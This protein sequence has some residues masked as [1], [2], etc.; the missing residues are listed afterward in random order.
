[1]RAHRQRLDTPQVN[2]VFLQLGIESWKPVLSA[3]LLP[4]VP[5]LVLALLGA[6]FILWRR[7]LGWLL[8]LLS[9][10]GLWL[11]AC[12]AVGDWLQAHLLSPP[13]ALTADA[14]ADLKRAAVRP[15]VAIVVLGGGREARAPEYGVASLS[16]LS[17]ERL[18]YGIWLGRE[19]GAPV[20]F[21]GGLGH[22]A[23]PGATEAEI[24]AEIAAREF[25]R[26]LRW[27]E[28]KARDTRE[29]AVF[30]T[31]LLREQGIRQLVIVTHGWH[32]PRAL[33]AFKQVADHDKL[34]WE[35]VPAPMGLGQR[36]ERPALRW[37]PSS[38]GFMS[39]RA[40]LR[41]RFGLWFGA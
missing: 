40:V 16:P 36:V 30:T 17:L 14:L 26:P 37:M 27:T 23:Q 13:P 41:E 1:M 29:N 20:M 5:W 32:M 24:A 33:R 6:R 18:R 8:V 35:L 34:T 22:A 2:D 39:V 19:T 38:E 9:V 10:L 4:P 11:S 7:G 28:S 12:S 3:L 21:S 25:V 15:G 31:T